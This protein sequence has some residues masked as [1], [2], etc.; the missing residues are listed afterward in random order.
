MATDQEMDKAYA[1]GAWARSKRKSKETCPYGNTE[2][3]L[4]CQWL[5]GWNDKDRGL[6]Q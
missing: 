5:G 3:N 4:R 1:D 6:I 2:I